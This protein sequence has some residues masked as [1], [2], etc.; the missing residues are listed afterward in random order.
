MSWRRVLKSVQ[1]L[2]AHTFLFTF[3]LLLVLKLDHVVF[4]SWWIIFLPVWLFH[5][6]VARGRF[7][8]PAPSIPRNRHWAPCHTVVAMPLLIAFELLLCI[9]LESLYVHGFPAV[10]LKI[11]FLPLLTFEIIILIDNFRMCRTLMP[12]DE[13][14][15]SDEAIWET[16][17]HFWVAISMVFFV[18]ATV[19]TLLKLCGY[20]GALGWWDLFINFSIAECFAFLVCTKWSN[21]VIHRNSCSRREASSSST[22]IRYLDW[23]SGLVVSSEENQHQDRICGLQDI[24]GHFMKI[25]VIGFQ[26]L[27][28]MR[29]EGTPARA[30]YIPLPVLFSP[31]F[32]L[33]GAAVLFAASRLVEKL[34]LLLRSGGG[35][36]IY[37]RFSSRAHD[38]LGF[39]H[40]GSRL[41]GWWSI[42]EGS[43]E[44]QARL[45]HEG[46]SGYNT[47]SGYPPEIVKKMPKKDLAEEVWRLQAALG[48]QTE[49][50]KYSQ[51]EFERLQ[52]EK[53]LCRVCFEREI[54]IVLL[55][56][57]H[58]VLCSTCCEKCK[59]CPICRISI[60]ECLPVYDV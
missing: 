14:S 41:L 56:C 15:I 51:Q 2:S 19:F 17:P 46:A 1:A 50:T 55:P 28:C 26:I 36:G 44:E 7:S 47:F 29:L 25:P 38:C 35:A 34:I 18:A 24:G 20:V 45:F 10:N 13:E 39:L 5:A 52:N 4:Y 9:Y 32:L 43:R 60:D 58:R 16:L 37:F 53:V 49:I 48:E 40:H 21:P 42:D 27:L 3:T 31:L 8:L 23:N 57:R 30:R 12:G 6:V 59:K 33:Q 11:V 54:S 22:T